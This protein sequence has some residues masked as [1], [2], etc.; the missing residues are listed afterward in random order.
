[1]STDTYMTNRPPRQELFDARVKRTTEAAVKLAAVGLLIFPCEELTKQ[2]TCPGGFYKAQG[3]ECLVRAIFLRYPG[4]L[5][6]VPTGDATQIDVLD[7]DSAK[8]PEAV[9]WWE[10]NKAQLPRTRIHKTR[11]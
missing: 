6:G 1:M 7:I 4:V 3:E 8:H 2:P 11:S 5:I 9:A 10:A